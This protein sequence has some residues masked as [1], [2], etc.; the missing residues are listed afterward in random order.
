[1]VDLKQFD[2]VRNTNKATARNFPYLC[3]MQH[4]FLYQ[5][6]TVLI[7]PLRPLTNVLPLKR[8]LNVKILIDDKPFALL[9]EYLSPELRAS[10]KS[11]VGSAAS[12]R[13]DIKRALDTIFDGI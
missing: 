11:V 1:M 5:L 10:L 6:D 7:A 13:E 8:Q 12:H 2:I 3:V 4:D 9:V